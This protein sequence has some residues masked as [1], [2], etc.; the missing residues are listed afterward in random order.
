MEEM[1]AEME[2]KIKETVVENVTD[3]TAPEKIQDDTEVEKT[4][5]ETEAENIADSYQNCCNTC[6]TDDKTIL[7]IL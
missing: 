7:Y 5:E 3:E 6:K 2:N 4:I 1:D